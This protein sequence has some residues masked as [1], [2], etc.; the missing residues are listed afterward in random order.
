MSELAVD[1]VPV[2]VA[3]RQG[4]E[5]KVAV[6]TQR[7]LIWWRFRKHKLALI[8]AA[9]V[10]LFYAVALF[11]DTIASTEP[12]DTQATRGYV[13]PQPIRWFD[14]EGH[15]HPRVFALKGKRDPR[16]FKLS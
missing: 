16:T 4:A 6:A 12:F 10:G 7:Q 14:A 8:S 11:A 2:A 15:F 9:I 5:T 13:P 3:E 1:S